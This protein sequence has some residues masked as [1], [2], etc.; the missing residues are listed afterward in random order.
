MLLWTFSMSPHVSVYFG[1]M[2]KNKIAILCIVYNISINHE[3][4]S[5]WN[6][7]KFEAF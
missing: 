4:A 2:S 6:G 7:T 3:L 1:F 5:T